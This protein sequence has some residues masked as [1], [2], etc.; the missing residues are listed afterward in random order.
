[1]NEP[2]TL[3]ALD[4]W[5]DHDPFPHAVIPCPIS[6]ELMDRLEDTWE[7]NGPWM[8]HSHENCERKYS[9]G[10]PQGWNPAA[11]AA[12]EA[13][14]SDAFIEWLRELSGVDDL[15]VDPGLFGGG[16]HTMRHGGHLD[17]HIDFN[18][19]NDLWRRVNVIC[20]VN[21][22]HRWEWGGAL[23]LE[24]R[25]GDQL[26]IPPRRGLVAFRYDEDALHGVPGRV[27]GPARKSIA[28]YYYSRQPPEIKSDHHH[29]T[30]Y[31]EPEI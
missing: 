7:E 16:L 20:F 26:D 4:D 30:I 25:H 1:L 2:L 6:D 3:P 23:V 10:H 24:G 15:T 22:L 21:R 13:L 11:T 29:S 12:I 5:P 17:M 8:I 18:R 9:C 31:Q 14:Q 28:M 19:S 27:R